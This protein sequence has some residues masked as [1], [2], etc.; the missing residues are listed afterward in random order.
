MKPW[1]EK[2]NLAKPLRE[3]RLAVPPHSRE[4]EGRVRERE[5][6]SFERGRIHGEKAL[7]EQL[8][9]QRRELLAL[10]NG[11]VQSLREAVPGVVRDTEK[12]LVELALEVAQKFVA[13]L[14]VSVEMIEAAVREALVEVGDAGDLNVTLHPNDLLLL[15]KANSPLTLGEVAGHRIR[16]G[17][18]SDIRP[19]G[20][21]VQT[22]F[23]LVDARRE[24][25]MERMR[26]SLQTA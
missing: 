4:V 20:C 17:S 26:R 22:G 24:T 15:Q 12:A 23:G 13:G 5:A 14:P 19:G 25:K 21:T 1:R 16:F 8:V 18:S 3:V 6:A 10:Q 7:A 9:A 2:M 11:V